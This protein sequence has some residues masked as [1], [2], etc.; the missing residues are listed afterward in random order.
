MKKKDLIGW[1]IEGFLE[2]PITKEISGIKIMKDGKL[3]MLNKEG[4]GDW[5]TSNLK[6]IE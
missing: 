4:K 6:R 5:T 2:H 1:T 3:K